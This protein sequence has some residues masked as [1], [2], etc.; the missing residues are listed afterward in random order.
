MPGTYSSIY[1][2]KIS[3]NILGAGQLVFTCLAVNTCVKTCSVCVWWGLRFYE[4]LPESHK[5]LRAP[6]AV[7][8][9]GVYIHA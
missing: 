4:P 3:I 1:V 5:G 6:Y 9:A 7:R 2:V 8:D